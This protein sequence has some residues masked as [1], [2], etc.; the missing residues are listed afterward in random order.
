MAIHDWIKALQGSGLA[1][2]TREKTL[3]IYLA[4][5][6]SLRR[7]CSF[8][9]SLNHTKTELPVKLHRSVSNTAEIV[10]VKTVEVGL[11][12]LPSRS[13]TGS[14]AYVLPA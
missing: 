1:K 9:P 11:R 10:P 6:Y 13:I 5:R 2:N 14:I 3:D 12:N 4:K 7:E 8:S